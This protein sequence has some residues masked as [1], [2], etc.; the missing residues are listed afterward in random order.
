MA[1]IIGGFTT[2]H[3]PA[4]GGAIARG[5]QGEEYWKPFFD[6][7]PPVRE[8]IARE[9]PDVAVIFYHD[10]G[11]G[12]FLDKMP[13]FALGCAASYKHADEGWGLPDDGVFQGDAKLSWHIAESLVEDEFDVTT[14]QE[15]LVDHAFKIPLQLL[16]P[17]TTDFPVR[18]VPI[19]LNSIQH[20]LPKPRRCWEL[21]RAVGRAIRSFP[22][23][24]KVLLI[25]SGGL[26]HQ[27]D[28]ERAGFLN[29][30]FD[31][32]CMERMIGEPEAMAKLSALDI[33]REAGAQGIELEAWIAMRGAMEGP[34]RRLHGGYHIPISNTAAA[35]L[36]L[37]PEAEA[38]KQAA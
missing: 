12:H 14:A 21:G 22:E 23:D 8:W 37:V 1:R 30:P 29:K 24:A 33:V 27:L 19:T 32:W 38:A 36:L 25:G 7:F 15:L 6:F 26:S 20:P 35:C 11:L 18:T 10:H 17:D 3:V 16:Y 28:G 5:R 13:T 9:K 34:A 2:S 31:L 4:I